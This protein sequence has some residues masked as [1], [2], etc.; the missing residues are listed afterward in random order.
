MEEQLN[1]YFSEY[2]KLLKTKDYNLLSNQEKSIVNRFSSE[3]EYSKMRN[4]ILLNAEMLDTESK[5]VNPNPEILGNLLN[6]L[7]SK[8][9]S[10]NVYTLTKSILSYKIPV[11]QFA[12][13]L[14][15]LV[16]VF[17]FVFKKERII[18]VEKPVYVYKTDTIEKFI[19]KDI[20]P[21][22]KKTIKTNAP[23]SFEQITINK[24]ELPDSTQIFDG[25]IYS[26]NSLKLMGINVNLKEKIENSRPKGRTMHDDS[27]LVKFLVKI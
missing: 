8:Q 10:N 26:K 22:L 18:N 3:E 11:Y 7:K 12:I 9:A 20:K 21:I 13:Y 27:M 2:E 4:I 25:S 5:T 19:V 17:L 1:K 15:V 16:F 14:I 24:N 6:T 23:K